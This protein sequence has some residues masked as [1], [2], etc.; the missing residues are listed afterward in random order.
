MITKFWNLNRPLCNLD[1]T[2]DFSRNLEILLGIFIMFKHFTH[3]KAYI[4]P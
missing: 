2:I 4:Q 3:E 1:L